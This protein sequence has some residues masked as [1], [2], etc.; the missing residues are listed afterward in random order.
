MK[1]VLF[2]N[3]CIRREDSRSKQLADHFIAE[4]QKTGKYDVETLCL[5]DENLSYFSDG[6]FLQRERLLAEG[7]LEHPRFRYAHQFAAADKIVI[8]AP[9]WDLSFP[10]LLKVYI[11]NICVD[12]ITFHT[13]EHGLKGLCKADHMV[14]LTARGGIYTDSDM[15]MGSAYLEKMAVFF[16]IDRYDCVAAE[17][18]DIGVWSE[19]ELLDK[20][21][22]KAAE[23]AKTF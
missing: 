22:A 8:A 4:L 17:G 12:G 18:L 10:A 6:F 16:G 5:M 14:Y 7:N 13:D 2:V 20:A 21:K 23:I 15:E 1:K 3:C 19:A 9:F 11:E